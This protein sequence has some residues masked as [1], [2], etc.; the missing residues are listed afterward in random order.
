MTSVFEVAPPPSELVGGSVSWADVE[1]DLGV[2]LPPDYKDVVGAYGLGA[3]GDFIHIFHPRSPLPAIDL[4]RMAGVAK[5]TFAALIE[6]GVHIPFPSRDLTYVGV[7]DNG[8]EIYALRVESLQCW[9]IVVNE[10]GWR[11]WFLFNGTLNE[12]LG[13]VL[14]GQVDVPVFPTGFPGSNRR[15]APYEFL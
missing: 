10:P 5:E 15:F 14:S 8:N 13:G 1:E 11:Q 3:F 2:E 9:E 4:I 7:T 12:F 6:I